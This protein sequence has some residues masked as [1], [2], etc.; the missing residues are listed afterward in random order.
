M[1]EEDSVNSS[2]LSGDEKRGTAT[3]KVVEEQ[4]KMGE[5]TRTNRWE[6]ISWSGEDKLVGKDVSMGKDKLLGKHKLVS[7]E[8]SKWKENWWMR[9]RSRTILWVVV[10]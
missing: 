10:S 5:I 1:A 9:N 7:G 2:R 6:T 3:E 8:E 4:R